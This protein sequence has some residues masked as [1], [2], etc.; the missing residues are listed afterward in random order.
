MIVKNE[1]HVI[2]SVLECMSKYIDYY[3]ISDTGSTDDTKKII[4]DY[5]DKINIEGEIYDDEWK[6]FG[7]NRSKALEHCVGKVEYCWV[8]DADDLIVGDIFLPEI[9]DKDSYNVIYGKDFCYRRKQIFKTDKNWR[10]V[11]VLH[12]YPASDTAKT[13]ANLEGDYY[14]DSR[15]LGDRNKNPDKY[16]KDVETLLK[17]LEDEPNND[18]Y[19]FYLAQSYMDNH[20]YENSNI[21]YLKRFNMG[22]WVEEQYFSLFK[23][24]EN[25]IK[26]RKNKDIIIESL[27][28][29]HKFRPSRLEALYEL[30][31]Y[32]FYD[33]ENKD[34]AKAAEYANLALNNVPITEDVLFV[35]MYLYQHKFLDLASL[36]YFYN[37]EFDKSLKCINLILER[38]KY[39]LDQLSRYEKNRGFCIPHIIDKLVEYPEEKIN[40]LNKY[41]KE[42]F[43]IKILFTI[44]TCKRID[45]FINTINSFINCCKDIDLIDKFICIDDNSSSIDRKIMKEKYP[46]F[47]FIYKDN[48]E[49]GHCISMNKILDLIN[50]Y[51]VKYL[52][53][54]EDDWNF[55]AERKYIID[56]LLIID[57]TINIKQVLFNKNYAEL[58]DEHSINIAGGIR[59]NIGTR[60]YIEH[61]YYEEGSAELF[62]F[63]NKIQGKSS[64]AYWPH[65]SFRPSIIDCNIF[66]KIGK[67]R[68]TNGHFEMDYSKRFY[69]KGY[70]SAFF[71]SLSCYHTGKLTNETNNDKPNAYNLNN[72]CQFTAKEN[73]TMDIKDIKANIKIVN[74]KR[75]DDRKE[76]MKKK[77]I[78]ADISVYD[79]IEAVDGEKLEANK[80]LEKLFR[81]NDF[82][83]RRGVI[84]CALSH[85]KLWQQLVEDDD[86]NYYIILEDDIDLCK[87]F[88]QKLDKL[89]KQMEEKD[90][91]FLGYSMYQKEREKVKEL[92]NNDNKNPIIQN[93]NTNLYVGGTF[94]Y[95]IN[96]IGAKKLLKYIKKNGI[97]HG[98]DYVMVKKKQVGLECF[99]TIPSMGFTE[100]NEEGKTI[101]SDIQ[102]NFES[103]DFSEITKN[104]DKFIFIPDKDIIGHD[105]FHKAGD[106]YDFADI[107]I[108]NDKCIAFNTAGYFKDTISYL[109]KSIYFKDGDGIY[110]KKHIYEK[111]EETFQ[112]YEKEKEKN[113]NI[114]KD[115]YIF[116]PLVDWSNNDCHYEYNSLSKLMKMGIDDEKCVGFNTLGFFKDYIDIYN[117]KH[118]IYFN[119]NDG[120]YIKK[121][122][123]EKIKNNIIRVKMLCNWCTSE[124]LCKEWSNMCENKFTWKNIEITWEDN[125]IDYYVIINYPPKDAFYIPEKTIVFQMEPWIVDNSKQWGVKTWGEW[126][127]PSVDK[128]LQ[129]RG[130]KTKYHNNAFWQL[131][132]NYN[133]LQNLKYNNKQDKLSSICSS[134]Y[135]DPGHIAR[136]DFLKFLETKGDIDI[137]IY[138]YDNKHNFK[139]YK[140]PLYHYIDKSKGYVPYKYYFMI[141]NNFETN[142]I[143]EKLW[144][145]I[146]SETLVFYYGCPNVSE[147][148]DEDAYVL[149]DINDFEKSYNIIKRA[150]SEDWW[151]QRISTIKR[152][153]QKILN[154]LQ[155]FPVIRNIISNDQKQ[156]M[157]LFNFL[158]L[159]KNQDISQFTKSN[160]C[161]HHLSII[162]YLVGKLKPNIIFEIGTDWGHF[163]YIIS[164]ITN[165]I[166]YS[167]DM[168]N[169]DKYNEILTQKSKLLQY[170]LLNKDNII[171]INEN[172]NTKYSEEFDKKIDILHFN[173]ITDYKRFEKIC[174]IFLGEKNKIHNNSII[175][176]HNIISKKHTIGKFFAD[177]QG[178][179][180]IYSE[181]TAGLGILSK[182]QDIINDIYNNF[183]NDINNP[184]YKMNNCYN[185]N[186]KKNYCFIHSC[187]IENKGTKRLDNIINYINNKPNFINSIEKIFI[188]NIGLAIDKDYGPKIEIT[189]YSNNTNLYEKCTLNKIKD[190]SENYP[191]V[192]ILYMHN[193]GISYDHNNYFINDWINY[194]LYFLIDKNEYC[195]NLLNNYN[196]IGVNYHNL[197]NNAKHYSGNFWWSNSDYLKNLDSLDETIEDKAI[198]E[199]W[200]LNNSFSNDK[201]K[202]YC[203]HY[204]NINHY[205][206]KYPSITYNIE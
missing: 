75:R 109:E 15:R 146:L 5:F 69:E 167:L 14:I 2:Q 133:E 139:N 83:S 148:I 31:N 67:Y 149:L 174:S 127:E 11:G 52:I 77:L 176:I 41:I 206:E 19:Y 110:I 102:N 62:E 49:K 63:Y 150:I 178:F 142:F 112:S 17:G 183:S 169:N 180:K 121:K 117:L 138:S 97:K 186:Q 98:I 8:I 28:R 21:Y 7:Y 205:L 57:N 201:L 163:P 185:N 203:L 125:F 177:I 128:F 43:S 3:I 70:K 175:L 191:D 18:R 196:T 179:Y 140:G 53:H 165:G 27:L 9:M 92:Y 105:L 154:E 126:A 187:T 168:F 99:E 204:S 200:L 20:E 197:N 116:F 61:E 58:Y 118:S 182:N 1:A 60:S 123:Y 71:E 54:L 74:L 137:D 86:Y 108:E 135:F 130:R 156:K 162:Q 151:T 152:E 90:I 24:G 195:I 38:Q 131:E 22:G 103:I 153:K 32:L 78:E 202:Y 88:G 39:P 91:V 173:N 65:F 190:F 59:K 158:N 34:I 159:Y 42:K 33:Q 119:A 76:N 164:P 45:L 184:L 193:K 155:F 124:Q 147:Y 113:N 161:I 134:F 73:I 115:Q 106:K 143:T 94:I 51:N 82:G 29:A 132:L 40:N 23:I 12:E 85:Y 25:N 96:K 122:Y 170:N 79:F 30:V 101:D 36:A 6:N 192:N 107:A 194:M 181:H 89:R 48:S 37:K 93:L 81:N 120:I 188:N 26:M 172:L 171:F 199:L 68:T 64:C 16:K 198:G 35:S 72:V 56:S 189:N 114:Y 10:Y 87:N 100:W 166:I 44:T 141:E 80:N 47:D 111:N 144:E 84:G 104:L 55:Y 66:K 46:F 145:P 13:E 157:Q 136:I 50:I 160:N 129:V 95:S 4:K